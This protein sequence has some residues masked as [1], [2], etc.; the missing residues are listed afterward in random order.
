MEKHFVN[1]PISETTTSKLAL[2]DIVY[3]TGDVYTFRGA[4]H[5]RAL[6]Y[7]RTGRELSF[8]LKNG[9]IHHCGP[10]VKKMDGELKVLVAAPTTSMTIDPYEAE[11]IE[12]LGVRAVIGKGGMGKG[13]EDAM[14]RFGCVYLAFT[15]GCGALAGEAVRKVKDVCWLDLGPIEAVWVL[16][17]K[18]FGPMVVAIDAHG[19]NLYEKVQQ[20]VSNKLSEIL[21]T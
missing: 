21:G 16:E 4:A 8:N 18:D 19:N 9:V 17:V 7:I 2:G 15:G 20:R 6:E 14:M 5:E 10:I 11:A 13:T 12:K 3:V 1:T